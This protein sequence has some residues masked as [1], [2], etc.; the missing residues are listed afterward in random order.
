[1]NRKK[2]SRDETPNMS[3]LGVQ[4]AFLILLLPLDKLVAKILGKSVGIKANGLGI[5]AEARETPLSGT[6]QRV[7]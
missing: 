5:R 2:L 3:H 1:M 4:P 6:Q 7:T